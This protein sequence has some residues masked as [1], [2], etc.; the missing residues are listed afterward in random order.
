MLLVSINGRWL[1]GQVC[2]K[3]LSLT[4]PWNSFLDLKICVVHRLLL[5]LYDLIIYCSLFSDTLS[6]L[7][8]VRADWWECRN[9]GIIVWREYIRKRAWHHRA[10]YTC[11]CLTDLR[12]YTT[13]ICCDRCFHGPDLNMGPTDYNAE[14]LGFQILVISFSVDSERFW[15]L[16][17]ESLGLCTLF[18][19]QNSI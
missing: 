6:V 10:Y 15:R 17:I 5:W 9:E 1:R 16:C 14:T 18:I 2:P 7:Y 11:I 8:C 3:L 12:K 13:N 19:V 4:G